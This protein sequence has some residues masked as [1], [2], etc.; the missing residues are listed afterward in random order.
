MSLTISNL[1]LE[2]MG[3]LEESTGALATD[4]VFTH[5]SIIFVVKQGD[6]G[7]VIGKQ[8]KNIQRLKRLFSREVQVIEGSHELKHF[9]S[10]L[11]APAAVQDVKQSSS[12]GKKVLLV[13]V[14]AKSKGMAIGSRGEKI[15]RA[16]LMLKRH[17]GIEE[18]KII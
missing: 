7:K 3:M 5:S 10:N 13:K 4:V 17:Y 2:A 9:V 12:Q 1:E 15:N 11:F 6:L 14:D 18:V 8:G 16:R